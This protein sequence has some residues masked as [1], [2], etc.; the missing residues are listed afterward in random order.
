MKRIYLDNNTAGIPNP[1]LIEKLSWCFKEYPYGSFPKEKTKI[2]KE[3][4]LLLGLKEGDVCRFFSSYE[5]AL[6]Q[7]FLSLYFEKVRSLGLNHLLFSSFHQEI[8]SGLLPHLEELNVVVKNLTPNRKGQITLEEVEASIRPRTILVS[9]EWAHPLTGVIYPIDEIASFCKSRGIL[10]HVDA[11]NVVGKHHFQFQDLPVD[12]LTLSGRVLGDP[13][14]AGLIVMK[15]N[16]VLNTLTEKAPSLASYLSFQLALTHSLEGFDW[17]TTEMVRLKALFEERIIQEQEDIE[18]VYADLDKLVNTSVIRFQGICVDA[19]L[20]YLNHSGIF[21]RAYLDQ[22]DTLSFAFG[23]EISEEEIEMI[24]NLI[25]EAVRKLKKLSQKI[26]SV[27]TLILKTCPWMDLSDKAKERILQ[28]RNGGFFIAEEAAL[29]GMRLVIGKEAIDGKILSL[30]LLVDEE[31]GVIA[32][33]RFQVYGDAALIAISDAA[34]D[35]LIRKNYEQ[36]RRLSADLLDKHLRDRA[37]IPAL[38]SEAASLLNLT[39]FAID[40]AVKGCMDIP[41]NSAYIASP[42]DM[43]DNLQVVYPDWEHL[44]AEKKKEVI[45]EVISRDI[46]PYIELDAGG[47]QIKEIKGSEVIIAYEGACTSC[48]SATG[49]TL[50]AIDQILK[51]RVHPSLNVI[52]DLSVLETHSPS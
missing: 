21:A 23:S 6:L 29:K 25:L 20:F 1:T 4:R 32:D 11:S 17:N 50:N 34:C 35:L 9:L 14:G 38:P 52:P 24:L 43:N 13:L 18:I 47:I 39:L 30:F 49:A 15:K 31:D 19:L 8:L 33:A 2:E 27:G 44:S 48:Y 28:P 36:A 40:E 51:T 41:L 26:E 42:I 5:K 12:F 45:E 10:V 7:L 46:R 22:K 16:E 3:I 37:N